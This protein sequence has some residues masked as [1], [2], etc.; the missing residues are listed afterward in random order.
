MI[1]KF[2]QVFPSN[3]DVYDRNVKSSGFTGSYIPCKRRSTD[4][5]WT[6]KIHPSKAVIA[7]PRSG[8][9][10]TDKLVSKSYKPGFPEEGCLRPAWVRSMLN[11]K[12]ERGIRFR[13]RSH[14]A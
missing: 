13:K 7:A 2:L 8:G 14:T 12:P 9:W 5:G 3:A 10:P 6:W 1:D 11:R 4:L